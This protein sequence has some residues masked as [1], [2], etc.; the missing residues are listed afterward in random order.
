M[1]FH[2]NPSTGAELPLEALQNMLRSNLLAGLG[3]ASGSSPL[4]LQGASIL[5]FSMLS[6]GALKEEF[7]L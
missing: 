5:R 6:W 2:R 1:A 4:Q 3:A 7:K